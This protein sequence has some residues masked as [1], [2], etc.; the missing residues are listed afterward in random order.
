M[1]NSIVTWDRRWNH[2]KLNTFTVMEELP[3]GRNVPRQII[4]LKPEVKLNSV[5]INGNTTCPLDTQKP[6]K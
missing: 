1:M 2:N 6:C 4:K 5:L 3:R